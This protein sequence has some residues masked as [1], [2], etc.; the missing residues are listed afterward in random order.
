MRI[1]VYV[2]IMSPLCRHSSCSQ[3]GT[4]EGTQPRGY[5][6]GTQISNLSR[7]TPRVH[8]SLGSKGPPVSHLPRKTMSR[9]GLYLT[10]KAAVKSL[11]MRFGGTVYASA[12]GMPGRPSDEGP[13]CATRGCRPSVRIQWHGEHIAHRGRSSTSRLVHMSV[14]L[15]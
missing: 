1:N 9:H 6:K 4:P 7:G 14:S 11:R 3:G 2:D 15:R 5:T 13:L 12:V 10:R 8:K